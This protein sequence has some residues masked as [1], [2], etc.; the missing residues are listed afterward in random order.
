MRKGL[1]ILFA[2]CA[3]AVFV[4]SI[5]VWGSFVHLK[6]ED[7]FGELSI[8]RL[9][10]TPDEERALTTAESVDYATIT[11]NKR[12]YTHGS[13]DYKHPGTYIS[14]AYANFIDAEVIEYYQE[15]YDYQQKQTSPKGVTLNYIANVTQLAHVRTTTETGAFVFYDIDNSATLTTTKFRS[16]TQ[17]FS[18]NQA[19]YQRLQSDVTLNFFD[20][21]F[22]EMTCQY[23]EYYAP[24]AAWW[25]ETH[26]IVI[27]DQNL[28]PILICIYEA[29]H[30]V[31]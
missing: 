28:T 3:I 10:N 5:F 31:A 8:I 1:I 14:Y 16:D 24:T 22:I 11:G 6:N 19:E 23:S 27:L 29:P 30:V 7:K 26:Q 2:I 15:R 25:A 4:V 9:F 21:Y 17:I 12:I 13:E 20:C 18:K